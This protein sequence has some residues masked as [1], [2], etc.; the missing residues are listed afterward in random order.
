VSNYHEEVKEYEYVANVIFVAEYMTLSTKAVFE[1]PMRIDEDTADEMAIEHAREFLFDHYG[2]DTGSY[3][4][5]I[6][7]EWDNFPYEENDDE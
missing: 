5:D 6:I 4:I 7:V 1:L 2:F 3:I